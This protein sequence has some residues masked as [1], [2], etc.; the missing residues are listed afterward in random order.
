MSEHSLRRC[1]R[2]PVPTS[3]PTPTPAP[4]G[5]RPTADRGLD[6]PPESPR[7]R[8]TP[9]DRRAAIV[10]ATVPLLTT[11]GVGVTTR[12]IAEAAGVAEGT[13]FRVFDDK[14][15]ILVAALARALDPEPVVEQVARIDAAR[16]LD[17]VLREVVEVVASRS[18]EIRGVMAVAHELRRAAAE[19][20]P[21]GIP[22]GPVDHDDP[23][24]RADL[25]RPG[26]L[27]HAAHQLRSRAGHTPDRI[28]AAIAEAL[29]G[30][31]HELRREPVVCARIL[32]SIVASSF[33]DPLGPAEQLTADEVVDMFLDGLRAGPSAHPSPTSTTSETSC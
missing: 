20:S 18:Q 6:G 14:H 26:S 17:A 3:V 31:R 9:D 7:A 19:R 24:V 29:A 1:Y 28:I 22:M 4:A 23:A 2:P 16:P 8:L 13:L 15:V 30:H 32:F 21:N 11:H 33:H 10:E 27:L 25:E 12:Q 5:S